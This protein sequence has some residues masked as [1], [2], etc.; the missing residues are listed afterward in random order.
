MKKKKSYRPWPLLSPP[1]R[2]SYAFLDIF[3]PIRSV[4]NPHSHACPTLPDTFLN[5]LFFVG[6]RVNHAELIPGGP[7]RP[8]QEKKREKKEMKTRIFSFSFSVRKNVARIRRVYIVSF[9]SISFGV[10]WENQKVC[11]R[12]D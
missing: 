8:P 10:L 4:P 2:G 3:F 7:T 12:D 1:P 11:S 9:L 5:T 6:R